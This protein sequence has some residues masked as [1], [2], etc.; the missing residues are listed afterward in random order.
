MEK[1]MPQGVPSLEVIDIGLYKYY[2]AEFKGLSAWEGYDYPYHMDGGIVS[3]Y[4]D[5]IP[6][7]HIEDE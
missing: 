2:S 6:L 3:G 5:D 1:S 7:K 4:I